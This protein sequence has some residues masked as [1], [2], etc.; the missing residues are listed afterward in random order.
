[1]RAYTRG[2]PSSH[3]CMCAW[4]RHTRVPARP[5]PNTYLDVAQDRS[6]FKYNETRFSTE[7]SRRARALQ[8]AAERGWRRHGA[9]GRA[10]G[11][12]GCGAALAG[13]VAWS[14]CTFGQ[15]A[16]APACCQP[17]TFLG[18]FAAPM[19]LVSL[20][21][22]PAL[23]QWVLRALQPIGQVE[24]PPAQGHN[25]RGASRG[26]Q[27]DN[28]EQQKPAGEG[29]GG[30]APCTPAAPHRKQPWDTVV[31]D[32]APAAR[33]GW[34]TQRHHVSLPRVQEMAPRPGA[35]RLLTEVRRPVAQT[36]AGGPSPSGSSLPRAFSKRFCTLGAPARHRGACQQVHS[37]HSTCAHLVPGSGDRAAKSEFPARRG[38]PACW[39]KGADKQM[40]KHTDG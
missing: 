9:A 4:H 11:L 23:R 6:W 16:G 24:G 18:P 8:G 37:F 30:R 2:R 13:P 28:T 33:S 31:G 26:H 19:A 36:P 21:H 25:H 22:L 5:A 32:Q 14:R 17:P 3:A 40:R 35:L 12:Q 15:D 27:Q 29:W 20:L 1:M 39:A 7:K 34:S 38:L 10:G